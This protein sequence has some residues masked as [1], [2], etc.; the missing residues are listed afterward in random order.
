MRRA[1]EAVKRC[2]SW[3]RAL[4]GGE[5]PEESSRE[6]EVPEGERR[7]IAREAV[8]LPIVLPREVRLSAD[9]ISIASE[10][11]GWLVQESSWSEPDEVFAPLRPRSMALWTWEREERLRLLSLNSRR[12]EASVSEEERLVSVGGGGE[13]SCFFDRKPVLNRLFFLGT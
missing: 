4:D 11:L 7:R 2:E 13:P 9:L 5:L 3:L 10:R 12:G 6:V 8:L 1:C